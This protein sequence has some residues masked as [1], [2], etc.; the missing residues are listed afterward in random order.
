MYLLV[1]VLGYIIPYVL[2]LI[3]FG[4]LFGMSGELNTMN[5]IGLISSSLIPS[6]AVNVM[7][8]L[9][10][11]TQLNMLKHDTRDE[12]IQDTWTDSRL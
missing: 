3:L 5:L 11:L 9:F 6:L 1:Y 8:I 7:Y 10:L 12:E 4:N 2:R